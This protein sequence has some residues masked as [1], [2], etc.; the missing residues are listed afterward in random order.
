MCFEKSRGL[1]LNVPL[2]VYMTSDDF[3]RITEQQGWK[4]NANLLLNEAS[5]TVDTLAAFD[6]YW[7]VAGH[8]VREQIAD[9]Q[10]LVR[11]LRRLLPPYEGGVQTL[12]RGENRDRW[13][14]GAVGFA[15]TP[16]ASVAR[17]F[18]RGLN[19][20]SF[21]GVLLK[22]TFIS[23]A[24]ICG[25]NSHSRHLGENQYTVDPFQCRDILILESYPRC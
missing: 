18:G 16:D 25:P 3:R 24:I 22:C 5:P 14:R 8:H 23:A 15:W 21:G 9:D 20:N 10:L 17:M 13:E 4:S 7:T 19:A 11:L 6:S 1:S 2:N 12:F